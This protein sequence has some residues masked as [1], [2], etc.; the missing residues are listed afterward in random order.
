MRVWDQVAL[1]VHKAGASEALVCRGQACLSTRRQTPLTP[2][3]VRVWQCQSKRSNC[4][5]VLLDQEAQHKAMQQQ[6]LK[7]W[8]T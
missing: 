1:L 2:I 5:L 8:R 3:V 7:A 4:C 6:R